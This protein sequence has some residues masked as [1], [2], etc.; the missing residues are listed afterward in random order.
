MFVLLVALAALGRATEL[1]FDMLPHERQCFM[2]VVEK[3]VDV[4]VEYQVPCAMATSWVIAQVVYGGRLDVDLE[5]VFDSEVV[6]SEKGKQTGTYT[7]KSERSGEYQFC[8]RY[9]SY[10][11]DKLIFWSNEM[12]T[13]A[14]KTIYIDVIVGAEAPI[15]SELKDHH[16]ALTQ[17]E[18]SLAAIHNSL[19]TVRF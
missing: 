19:R 3:D 9:P 18:S 12:S 15:L 2:E 10:Y 11:Y 13:M 1:T 17:M 16:V 7:F 6:H 14:H 5:V 8:F 4:T